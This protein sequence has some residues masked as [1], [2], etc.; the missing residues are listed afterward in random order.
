MFKEKLKAH[1]DD[2]IFIAILLFMS[3]GLYIAHF[4]YILATHNIYSYLD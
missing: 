4:F 1:K 3:V 2:I